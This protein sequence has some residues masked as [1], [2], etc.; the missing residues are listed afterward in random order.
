MTNERSEKIKTPEK[1]KAR[2]SKWP[3][4]CKEGKIVV[5]T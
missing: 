3:I 4:Q 5:Y 1:K 2:K